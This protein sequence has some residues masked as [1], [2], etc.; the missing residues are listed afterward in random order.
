[1]RLA[2]PLE[3]NVAKAGH[4][5]A[6]VKLQRDNSASGTFLGLFVNDLSEQLGVD[7][8]RQAIAAS[9]NDVVVPFLISKESNR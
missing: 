9:D 1:M 6:R 3:A 7:I 5:F 2:Q 4:R 8:L